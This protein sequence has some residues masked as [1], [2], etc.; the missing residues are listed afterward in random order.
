MSRDKSL[1]DTLNTLSW[2]IDSVQKKLN[3][4]IE[5]KTNNVREELKQLQE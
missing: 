3:A 4:A 2:N 5:L 1:S